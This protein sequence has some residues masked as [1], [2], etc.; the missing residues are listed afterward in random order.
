[1]RALAKVIVR[2]SGLLQIVRQNPG[3]RLDKL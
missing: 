3:W 1:M 2:D